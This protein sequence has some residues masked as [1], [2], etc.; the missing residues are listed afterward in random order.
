M[1]RA[2]LAAASGTL[3]WMAPA[4]LGIHPL[5]RALMSEALPRLH[6]VS[7]GPHI[8]LTYDDGPDPAATPRF[9]DLLAEYRAHATFFLLGEH[10]ERE[11]DLV[12]R[13]VD[14][15]H[16]IAV[17]G[18]THRC[19]V[20]IGPRRLTAELRRTRH[21][22]E[23]LGDRPVRWYRP[24]YG[25]LT[26]PSLVAARRAGLSSVL[27]SAWGIDWRRGRT[28]QNVVD[29]VVGDLRPGGTILLHD[30]DRT[31]TPGSW[32]TTLSASRTLLDR[33]HGDGV[34]VGTLSDHWAT[35]DTHAT[36]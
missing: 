35:P 21:L 28:P 14:E 31:S 12:R 19:V 3:V 25:V 23:Q 5:R 4:L 32:E 7:R 2:A 10:A 18:W 6:G 17:H 1:N 27:W 16:E 30:T 24:P 33:F 9:L 20:A 22:L 34:T 26:T 29:T 36:A 11:P 15:G 13:I 8:S